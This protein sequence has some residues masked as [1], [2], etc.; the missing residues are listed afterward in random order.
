[1]KSFDLRENGQNYFVIILE[2]QVI[3][4]LTML[5]NLTFKY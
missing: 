3:Q 1:M 2:I 5:I 4:L